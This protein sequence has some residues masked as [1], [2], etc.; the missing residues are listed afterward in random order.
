MKWFVEKL[1]GLCYVVFC[2]GS[3]ALIG[4][5]TIYLFLIWKKLVAIVSPEIF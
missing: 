2:P 5:H 3:F 1:F 4:V